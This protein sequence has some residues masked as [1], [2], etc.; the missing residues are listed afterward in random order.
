MVL[1]LK[2]IFILF[3]GIVSGFE[4]A[5]IIREESEDRE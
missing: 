4:I 3:V 5:C 1:V 2:E